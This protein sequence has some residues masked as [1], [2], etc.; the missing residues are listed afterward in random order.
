M[1]L[2]LIDPPSSGLGDRLSAWLSLLALATLRKENLVFFKDS[3]SNTTHAGHTDG[4]Q[5]Q[6][7]DVA[8]ALRCIVW[9]QHVLQVDPGEGSWKMLRRLI[10]NETKQ[11]AMEEVRL[12]MASKGWN[13]EPLQ[14]LMLQTLDYA[15][16]TRT[17]AQHRWHPGLVMVALPER[18][19]SAFKNGRLL[20][21]HPPP[22]F[23]TYLAAYHESS[24][25]VRIHSAC[26]NEFPEVRTAA[27]SSASSEGNGTG[28]VDLLLYAHLR[29][30]DTWMSA[31]YA[32]RYTLNARSR[33][34]FHSRTRLAIEELVRLIDARGLSAKWVIIS[35]NSTAAKE[36]AMWVNQT[37]IG[38]RQ[39]AEVLNSSCSVCTML[40][41]RSADGIL[42]SSL[43]GFSSFS[44]VPA[45]MGGLPLYTVADSTSSMAKSSALHTFHR[46]QEAG[47]LDAVQVQ[48]QARRRLEPASSSVARPRASVQE[49]THWA[50]ADVSSEPAAAPYAAKKELVLPR[51]TSVSAPQLFPGEKPGMR[52][53]QCNQDCV[54]MALLQ[55]KR[56]GF[57][58]DLAANHPVTWS[59]TKALER[60]FGWNGVCVEPNPIYHNMLLTHR[61]CT[62]VAAAVG[63]REGTAL[64]KMNTNVRSG[65]FGHIIDQGGRLDTAVSE[66]TITTFGRI[67]VEASVP[68]HID[69]LSLDVEGSELAVMRAFPYEAY[70]IS[71]LSVENPPTV[72]V[73]LL[74]SRGYAYLC[75]NGPYR[76]KLFA[77]VPTMS[78]I[79][80][81]V[82]ETLK[83]ARGRDHLGGN[84]SA[85]ATNPIQCSL[86]VPKNV[87]SVDGRQF[88]LPWSSPCG[89][90]R[91]RM[92]GKRL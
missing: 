81:Q 74:A 47:F 69:F 75:D 18:A 2:G 4:Q 50:Q 57:F 38:Q 73:A 13:E 78:P 58:V 19:Y 9:P 34:A 62:V 67:A 3:W 87:S 5:N 85:L 63:S 10:S 53:S 82:L 12:L 35:D 42:Q 72:L 29:R 84:A 92:H 6:N 61:A 49:N 20:P 17:S 1:V 27:S 30:G 31:R 11:L 77:H 83:R 76:D 65:A 91:K 33:D 28:G 80:A 36:G 26:D 24:T 71:L 14:P 79:V 41:M 15:N 52:H 22:S 68:A 25:N 7:K 48:Q 55:L 66:V 89:L 88:I 51:S 86:V 54:V 8:L 59:N 60:D 43:R 44:L 45:L 64:F 56:G 90:S 21:A 46:G 32:T 23:E 70:S 39:A 37:S 40:S 16:H